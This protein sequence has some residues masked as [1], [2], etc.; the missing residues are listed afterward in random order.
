MRERERERERE[1]QNNTY[2]STYWLSLYVHIFFSFMSEILMFRKTACCTPVL[3][4]Y[5]N[6]CAYSRN[7]FCRER[8]GS[9]ASF[10]MAGPSPM[11]LD[12]G[13]TPNAEAQ[14]SQSVI[15]QRTRGRIASVARQAAASHA[16]SDMHAPFE[17]AT[18]ARSIQASLP[19]S[20]VRPTTAQWA[21]QTP[22][23]QSSG[24]N[25][26]LLFLSPSLP[27]S[28]SLSLS[29]PGAFLSLLL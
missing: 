11:H 16:M 2:Y 6:V 9:P 21:G 18:T 7:V 1:R 27:L 13:V 19:L 14:Q 5:V 20:Q 4:I 29:L 12:R 28:H 26:C 17:S 15:A 24:S 22:G 3:S 10:D 23:R 8:S 25:R